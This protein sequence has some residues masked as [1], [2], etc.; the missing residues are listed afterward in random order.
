MRLPPAGGT[1]AGTTFPTGATAKVGG[2][3]FAR[4]ATLGMERKSAARL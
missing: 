4:N 1:T 3:S 2:E